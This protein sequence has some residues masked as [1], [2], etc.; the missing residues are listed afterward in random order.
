MVSKSKRGEQARNYFIEIEKRY[1]K[2]QSKSLSPEQEP[3]RLK[4]YKGMPVLTIMDISH[5]IGTTKGRI[6]WHIVSE[7]SKLVLGADYFFLQKNDLQRYKEKNFV[8]PCAVSTLMVIV[9][10][11]FEKI[12]EGLGVTKVPNVYPAEKAVREP[13][14]KE[15]AAM[16]IQQLDIL[17]RTLQYIDNALE[18]SSAAKYITHEL[19]NIGLWGPNDAGFKGITD[20]WNLGTLEGWNKKATIINARSAI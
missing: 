7:K 18:R 19:I 17:S 14:Q 5:I 4:T 9:K 15:Y 10:T 8:A 2:L 11:G 12:C 13:F 3:V 6:Y 16:K 20:N 1:K